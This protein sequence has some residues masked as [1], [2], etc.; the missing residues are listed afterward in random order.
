MVTAVSGNNFK[1]ATVIIPFC[2]GSEV[3]SKNWNSY[4]NI[5]LVQAESPFFG[6]RYAKSYIAHSLVIL[7]KLLYWYYFASIPQYY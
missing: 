4:Y 1:A 3:A 2:K 7:T 6:D 5:I